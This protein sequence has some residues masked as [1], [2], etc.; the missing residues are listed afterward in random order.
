MMDADRTHPTTHNR[1]IQGI[2]AS[3]GIAIGPIFCSRPRNLR[4]PQNLS[5]DAQ[6]ELNRFQ[7][8][9]QQAAEEIK[10]LGARIATRAGKSSAAIFE[11]HLVMLSD[12]MLEELVQENIEAGQTAESA[13]AQAADEL[14]E[15]LGSVEHEALAARSTDIKDVGQ[16]ILRILLGLPDSDL[17]TL[18]E[19]SV[20]AAH[21][22]TPSDTASL[23][24]GLV[25]GFCT[26]VG[27]PTSHTAIL[28]RTLGIPAVVGIGEEALDILQQGQKVIL[29]GV[30]GTLIIDP[31]DEQ[32]SHHQQVSERQKT[33]FSQMQSHAHDAAHT[34][35]GR[36]IEVAANVGSLDSARE[37]VKMGA[38]GIGLLRTEFLY[39][40]EDQSPGEERQVAA[41]QAILDAMED[42]P[43][44]IRTLDIGGD[45]P[46]SYLPV[47][48]EMNPFLGW[49]GIRI[50][51]DNLPLF[52]TQ[53]R[54]I[55]RAA[56][57]RDVHIMYPM[58]SGIEELR[59]A[60]AVLA[61]AKDELASEGLPHAANPSVGIMVETPAAVLIGDALASECD[62]FSVGSN[63]LT[64]YTLAVDRTNEHVSGLY[65]SLH[66]AVLRAIKLTI[67]A[68]HAHGKWVG[69]CGEMAGMQEAIP[70]LLGL[71][72]D[73]FSMVSRAIPKAKWLISQLS[74]AETKELADQALSLATVAEIKQLVGERLAALDISSD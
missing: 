17:S 1:I 47:P 37:A 57:D 8:A 68:A 58:I 54:A 20:I 44:I 70:I 19:P 3:E 59:R 16:R 62:F 2:P 22:L 60:N 74:D 52:K 27:G 41:Y 56:A 55:L 72:L 50:C 6:V 9:R 30:D 46:L 12:P 10:A 61:E 5:P 15:M 65:Q 34:A 13:V 73:E 32:I 36:R 51:L 38:E 4:L 42:R 21:D 48:T 45:K 11:A 43:V 67:D 69:I 39:L 7:S 23:E 66:P 33:Q 31:T 40:E 29:N 25:L 28:A 18:I 35:S 49:R 24:P 64:Q 14:A 53:L 71:G 26:A 63:D